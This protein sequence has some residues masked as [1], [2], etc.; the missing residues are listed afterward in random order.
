[1]VEKRRAVRNRA[2]NF[3]SPA[4]VHRASRLELTFRARGGQTYLAEQFVG[5]PLKILRPF[6]LD[7]GRVVLQILNVGPGI[8]Q[9]DVFELNIQ[10]ETGAKVVLV[11]QSATKLHAMPHGAAR[12]TVSLRV[13]TGAELEVYPG[14]VIPYRDAE[15]YQRTEVRLKR[16]ARFGLLERW[17]VGRVAHGEAFGFRRLSSRLHIQREGRLVYADGLELTPKTASH[18]GVSDGHAYLAAWVWLWDDGEFASATE[19]VR[20]TLAGTSLVHGSFGEGLYLRCLGLDGL[21]HAAASARVVQEWRSASGL[22]RIDF[23]RFG[24]GL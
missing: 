16:G 23:G 24:T 7:E 11:T 10:V 19:V 13:E 12:Q 17:S 15:F 6:A 5:S 14:L 21:E 1:M 8:M 20:P 9:G 3:S 4:L 2:L 22:P 18:L